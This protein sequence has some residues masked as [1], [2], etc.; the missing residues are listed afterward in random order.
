M[1]QEQEQQQ[2]KMA[3]MNMLAKIEKENNVKIIFAAET[4]ARS[5]D[6]HSPQSD[7]DVRVRFIFFI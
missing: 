3:V 2:G 4:G 7:Y 6:L 5:Y 1:S